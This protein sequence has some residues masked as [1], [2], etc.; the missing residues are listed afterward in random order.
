MAQSLVHGLKFAPSQL[1]SSTDFTPSDLILTGL[2]NFFVMN[3]GEISV[4]FTNKDVT[5]TFKI[6]FY[7]FLCP[8]NAPC[9]V[10]IAHSLL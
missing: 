10:Y 1:C 4:H 2:F 9:I 5:H 6:H 7:P 8:L 3:R